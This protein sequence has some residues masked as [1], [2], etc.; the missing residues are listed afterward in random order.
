MDNF[1]LI[2]LVKFTYVNI[3]S[4]HLS[5]QVSYFRRIRKLKMEQVVC[6]HFQTGFCKFGGH[7]RKQHVQEICKTKQCKYKVFTQR[8]PDSCKYFATHNTCK[9]GEKCAYQHKISKDKS[10]INKLVAIVGALENTIQV[11][12]QNIKVLEDEL[13]NEK[14]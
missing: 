4:S 8:H 9:F 3:T 12:S 5:N 10:K 1:E 2:L 11:M 6:H 7:C 13:Q 14:K